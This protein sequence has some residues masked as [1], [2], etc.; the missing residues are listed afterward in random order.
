MI[1]A[2][3]FDMD[4]VII[5][6]EDLRTKAYNN[7]LQKMFGVQIPKGKEARDGSREEVNAK[8]FFDMLNI[9]GD[10]KEFLKLKKEEYRKLFEKNIDLC[11]GAEDFLKKVKSEKLLTAITTST[12]RVITDKILAQLD[13]EKYF[14]LVITAND[15]ENYKP[16][17]DC[18][19]KTV[20][21]LEIDPAECFVIEDSP[22][23]VAAAKAANLKCVAITH[24]HHSDE[25]KQADLIVDS[26]EEINYT[27]ISL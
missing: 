14:N 26:F 21:E 1:K 15:V 4:G 11:L 3:I 8:R 22:I 16:E 18:Y 19:L 7:A 20:K 27:S 25:L 13:L 9:K 23:G 12:G 6:S 17:P 10:T 24:T 5:D 2:I